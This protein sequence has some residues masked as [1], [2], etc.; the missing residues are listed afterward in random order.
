MS[1]THATQSNTTA[2]PKLYLALELSWNSWKLAFT[3]GAGR[4]PRLR[5]IPARNLDILMPEIHHAPGPLWSGRGDP[6]H[7]RLRG[8]P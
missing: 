1:A 2:A 6:R 8:R 4:K 5:T 3:I 7:L